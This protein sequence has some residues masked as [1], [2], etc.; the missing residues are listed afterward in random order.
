[1]TDTIVTGGVDDVAAEP[2]L[3]MIDVRAGYG[4]IEVL[5]GVSLDV[6]RGEVLALLGAERRRQVDRR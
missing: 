3:E 5:H 6:Q 1:M 2:I 4:T